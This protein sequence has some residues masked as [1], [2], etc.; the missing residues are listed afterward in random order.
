MLLVVVVVVPCIYECLRVWLTATQI[1]V[2]IL[3]AYIARQ[4]ATYLDVFIAKAFA[5]NIALHF[6]LRAAVRFGSGT[7]SKSTFALIP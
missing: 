7:R 3:I 5:T 1:R 4:Q 6:Y 2:S